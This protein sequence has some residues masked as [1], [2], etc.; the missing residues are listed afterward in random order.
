[1]FLIL[2]NFKAPN[3]EIAL[4]T[5]KQAKDDNT[6]LRQQYGSPHEHMEYLHDKIYKVIDGINL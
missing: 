2:T 5:E 1:M 3:G 6:Q 4:L